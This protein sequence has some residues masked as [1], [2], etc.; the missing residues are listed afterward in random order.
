MLKI[1]KQLSGIS[2]ITLMALSGCANQKVS[3]VTTG[4][5]LP[6]IMRE[7]EAEQAMVKAPITYRDSL[8]TIAALEERLGEKGVK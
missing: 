1:S 5:N 3:P 8:E 2:L 6:R 7:G 4:A